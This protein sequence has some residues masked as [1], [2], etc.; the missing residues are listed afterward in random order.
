MYS[1]VLLT[2]GLQTMLA[3]RDVPLPPLFRL[4]LEREAAVRC[5]V[6]P[7][8][9]LIFANYSRSVQRHDFQSSHD[10]L[11]NILQS[12]VQKSVFISTNFSE[13][14]IYLNDVSVFSENI[15]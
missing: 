13:I 1:G 5:I 3:Q 11:Q 7:M 2:A 4:Y 6:G 9:F 12:T 15:H 10:I 8:I 14:R